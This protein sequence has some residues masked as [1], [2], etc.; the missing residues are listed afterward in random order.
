[1]KKMLR[2]IFLFT[3]F[4]PAYG[5]SETVYFPES[6]VNGKELNGIIESDPL[7]PEENIKSTLIHKGADLSIHLV[8]IRVSEKPHTHK[9][10]DLLITMKRGKGRLHLGK[11]IIEIAEGDTALIP[12]GVPHYFENTGE[13]IAAGLGVFI[14]AFDGKDIIPADMGILP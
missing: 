3:L 5:F 2:S 11:D 13:G 12:K 9:D 4:V 1:M 7:G 14:P 10:H 6:G 8:R